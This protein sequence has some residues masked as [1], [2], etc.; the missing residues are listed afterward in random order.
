MIQFRPAELKDAAA[1]AALHARSWQIHYRGIYP[2]QYLDHEVEADRSKVWHARL[3]NPTPNQHIIL[4]C[5]G[6]TPIG[7]ACIYAEDHLT[8][9]ALLDNLHVS[10]EYKGK[11]IGAQLIKAVGAWVYA[12]N[13][14][15]SF[16]LWVLEKNVEAIKFYERMGGK[17]VELVPHEIPGG[18]EAVVYRYVWTDLGEW[19][20]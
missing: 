4:A 1:I 20:K 15:E 18:Q 2:D 3:E 5:D 11:G 14:Q 6:D 16:Y 9:G 8:W 17:N 10:L 13:P 7:F 12:R 19:V